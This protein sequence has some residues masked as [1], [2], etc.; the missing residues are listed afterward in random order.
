MGNNTITLK[1]FKKVNI[2]VGK[3]LSAE[4]IPDTDKLL[5]LSVDVGEEKPR[6]IVSGI[7]LYFPDCNILIGRK[8]MF[9]TNLEPRI[10]REIESQGM[11]LAVSAQDGRFSLLEPS[12]EIPVG[13]RAN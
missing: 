6:Q 13:T 3:I 2:I 8:C 9:V 10:I 5:K 12:D 1:D 7:S 11:I 4:K